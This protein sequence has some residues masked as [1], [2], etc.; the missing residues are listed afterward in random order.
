MTSVNQYRIPSWEFIL[1]A[2]STI[3]FIV[4]SVQMMVPFY[5][6][7]PIE[8]FYSF[9]LLSKRYID[10]S[11]F[12]QYVLL[13]FFI[14][15]LYALLTDPVSI[16]DDISYRTT[17]RFL[18]KFMQYSCMFFPLLFLKR[19]IMVGTQ[20]Q[21]TR[22]LGI[23]VISMLIACQ[24]I[25]DLIVENSLAAREFSVEES[26]KDMEGFVVAYPFVY[27]MSFVFVLTIFLAIK[28]RIKNF[29]L[30]CIF[31]I[32]ALF[33]LYFLLKAQFTLALLTS[34]LSILILLMREIKRLDTF[35]L[36][37][38]FCFPFLIILPELFRFVITALPE[39][40]SSRFGEVYD[41]YMGNSMND[42]SDLL[43]RF[44]LYE[45]SIQAFLNSPI[46]GNRTVDF[47]GHATY[48]MVWADLGIIGGIP[49]FTLLFRSKRVVSKLLGKLSFYFTPFFIHL[50]LN[51]LTNPIHASLQIYICVWFLIPLS[52]YAFSSKIKI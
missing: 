8:I 20:R 21:N 26:T 48:L 37:L 44:A 14:S 50:F 13:I 45:K 25:L 32:L 11:V 33:F 49:I 31:A 23:S 34:I 24:S 47:D 10:T 5:A 22:L 12:A 3:Y 41:F 40:L 46:W 6:F 35:I 27:G 15:L 38:C 2:I 28:I 1:I 39:V 43:G 17:K 29:I 16:A 52:L 19:C 18:S 9:Y 30:K 42:D 36:F 4:P 51:G 7:L